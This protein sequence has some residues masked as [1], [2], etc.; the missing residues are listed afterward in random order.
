MVG[1][2]EREGKA[3]GEGG[4][5]IT[6]APQPMIDEIQSYVSS[7]EAGWSKKAA[8][9]GVNGADVLAEMRAEI[10]KLDAAK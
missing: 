8:E 10:K 2:I 6:A 9:F 3:L 5:K 4:G 7:V 1:Q